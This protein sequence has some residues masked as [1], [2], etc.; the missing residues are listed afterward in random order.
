[1]TGYEG[2]KDVR[3]ETKELSPFGQ[4]GDGV[5][6][7]NTVGRQVFVARTSGGAGECFFR[8][9]S[10]ALTVPMIQPRWTRGWNAGGRRARQERLPETTNGEEEEGGDE[11]WSAF[12]GRA[13]SGG[14]FSTNYSAGHFTLYQEMVD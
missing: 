13:S 10:F 5:K 2:D 6:I 1:L 8:H 3:Q 14:H 7:G 9:E 4:D 12:A 11:N